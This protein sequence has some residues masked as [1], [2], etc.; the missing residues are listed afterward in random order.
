MEKPPPPLRREVLFAAAP[1]VFIRP[2]VHNPLNNVVH[3]HEHIGIFSLLLN[4]QL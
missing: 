1:V 3:R 4:L 2:T